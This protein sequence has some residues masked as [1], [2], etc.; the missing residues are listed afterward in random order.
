[1]SK[2]RSLNPQTGKAMIVSD[3]DD[4]AVVLADEKM[5][6]EQ[7]GAELPLWPPEGIQEHTLAEH[8]ETM[9]D[10]IVDAHDAYKADTDLVRRRNFQ[11]Q[12]RAEFVVSMLRHRRDLYEKLVAAGVIRAPAQG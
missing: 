11:T 5:F 1:M 8:R 6:C 10:A 9:W 4:V 3:L 2:P 7:C 12:F